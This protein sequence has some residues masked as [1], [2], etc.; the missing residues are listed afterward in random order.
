[1]G[2][3]LKDSFQQPV[4]NFVSHCHSCT[5]SFNNYSRLERKWAF[6]ISLRRHK[7]FWKSNCF[8]LLYCRK[9]NT[10]RTGKL[11]TLIPLRD[12]AN[13]NSHVNIYSMASLMIP[14]DFLLFEPVRI[15]D[16]L[17]FHLANIF[18]ICPICSTTFVRDVEIS[19]PFTIMS[20][21]LFRPV[22]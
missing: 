4:R 15:S 19:Q 8:F 11:F 21:T 12:I 10:A 5:R 22:F 3:L 16:R 13:R 9:K 17:N 1:M 2:H 6:C 14:R 18:H 7:N 20:T